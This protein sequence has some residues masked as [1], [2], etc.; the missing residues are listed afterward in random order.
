VVDGPGVL[1]ERVLADQEL[2]LELA[3]LGQVDPAEL[4][5]RPVLAGLAMRAARVLVALA[6]RVA[7]VLVALAV[8]VA[9]VLGAL[10]V[11]VARVLVALAPVVL[12]A[13]AWVEAAL[14]WA[15]A[16]LAP[17]GLESAGVPMWAQAQPLLEGR[18]WVLVAAPSVGIAATFGTSIPGSQPGGSGPRFGP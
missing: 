5:G 14:A 1:A 2:V 15:Q 4:V 3:E 10:A 16:E 18:I 9:W 17:A 7:W 11:R 12:A 13:Q 6:V 8:R